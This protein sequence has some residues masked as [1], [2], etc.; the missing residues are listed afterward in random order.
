MMSLESNTRSR[1]QY[2]RNSGEDNLVF[3]NQSY[4]IDHDPGGSSVCNRIILEIRLVPS[5]AL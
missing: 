5:Y 3:L 4:K 1:H 2:W